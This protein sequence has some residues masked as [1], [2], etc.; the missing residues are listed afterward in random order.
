MADYNKRKML[1]S[2]EELFV[3]KFENYDKIFAKM[4]DLMKYGCHQRQQIK[5]RIA[6][7]KIKR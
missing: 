5:K 7:P 2:Q 6:D 1:L 4:I 3:Q